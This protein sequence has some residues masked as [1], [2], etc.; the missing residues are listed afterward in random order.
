MCTHYTNWQFIGKPATPVPSFGKLF[1]VTFKKLLSNTINICSLSV[2]KSLSNWRNVRATISIK[3][4]GLSKKVNTNLIKKSN[5][6]IIS[7]FV[8]FPKWTYFSY[9]CI[10]THVRLFLFATHCW[11]WCYYTNYN[12]LISCFQGVFR[13]YYTIISVRWRYNTTCLATVW[14]IL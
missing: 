12:N 2:E 3:G 5:T 6:T 8:C 14:I 10:L 4:V 7:I 1:C 13:N 9:I 11:R